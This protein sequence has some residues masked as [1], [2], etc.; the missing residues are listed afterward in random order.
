MKTILLS[1]TA[2]A[3]LAAAAAPAAA[4]PWRDPNHAG[5]DQP[6]N[7]GDE[8]HHHD[9]A[10]ARPAYGQDPRQTYGHDQP[11]RV[12]VQD[13]QIMRRL[14]LLDWKVDHSARQHR[15]SWGDARDLRGALREVKPLALR[16]QAGRAD[17]SERQRV[18]QTLARVEATL[19]NYAQ[20]DHHDLRR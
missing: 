15:I 17:G 19:N 11:V 9:G 1:L 3:A 10:D 6:Q 12:E 18:E 2:V 20:N 5:Y 16:V 13:R 7:S 8:H 14:Y 4:Q